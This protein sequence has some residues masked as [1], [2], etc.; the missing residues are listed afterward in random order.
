[1]LYKLIYKD[2][3]YTSTGERGKK[4]KGR[5]NNI[6]TEAEIDKHAYIGTELEERTLYRQRHRCRKRGTERQTDT[7]RRSVEAP[8]KQSLRFPFD[9]TVANDRGH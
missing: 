7:Q 1:M 6:H 2:K 5:L 9:M 3:A 8:A 4:R